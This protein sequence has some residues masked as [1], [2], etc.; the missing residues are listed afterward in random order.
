MSKMIFTDKFTEALAVLLYRYDEAPICLR[1]ED[2]KKYLDA[3]IENGT[4][5][6]DCFHGQ[7]DKLS[8]KTFWE[9]YFDESYLHGS[10][11]DTSRNMSYLC[12]I[13]MLLFIVNQDLNDGN[14]YVLKKLY[15]MNIHVSMLNTFISSLIMDYDFESYDT[16]DFGT[17]YM[18]SPMVT[19][20]IGN[21][22]KTEIFSYQYQE[23]LGLSE[24]IF[25]DRMVELNEKIDRDV[26]TTGI[27]FMQIQAILLL[28]ESSK[29]YPMYVRKIAKQIL[30]VFKEILANARIK[31]I[32]IDSAICS[33]I[34]RQGIKKTTGM[35]I[36][37]ALENTDRFCLR[38]DFP[39]DG[40]VFLHL[41]LHEP[42]RATA[43]PINSKQYNEIKRQ[44]GELNDIFFHFGNLYWFRYNFVSKL[45]S[46]SLDMEDNTDKN[47]FKQDMLNLFYEQ[48]HYRMCSE[49]ITKDNMFDFI[50]EFGSALIHTQVYGVSYSYTEIENINDELTKI[51][52]RDIL[53]SALA[54]YQ[55]FCLEER[56]LEKSYKVGFIKLKN[57][58]LNALFDHFQS[59][60]LPLG[61]YVEFEKME[62]EEIF[63]LLDDIING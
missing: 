31:K 21:I 28:M 15:N 56:I 18:P 7:Y 58:L 52:L 42:Y 34:I 38:I 35:K 13:F 16:I 24:E 41:N 4:Y 20:Y 50:A 54:L 8:N 45:E 32:E 40:A 51:K 10:V 57:T 59:E 53:S 60:V 26:I 29:V 33:G 6:S 12:A 43:L 22:Y 23:M 55:R 2:M 11:F 27:S 9:N 48:G 63:L 19:E 39:H 30:F 62:L 61:N 49:E 46:I 36:F 14:L 5:I 37:F 3:V 25:N 17:N 44:Y 47:H 1:D